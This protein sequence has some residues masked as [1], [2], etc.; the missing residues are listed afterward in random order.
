[1]TEHDDLMDVVRRARPDDLASARTPA[2]QALLEE[3]LS[4]PVTRTPDT[5]TPETRTPE[6]RTPEVGNEPG[7]R[8]R[9]SRHRRL[10]LALSGAAAAALAAVILLSGSGESS[11]AGAVETAL[12]RSSAMLDQSGRAEVTWRTEW[13]DDMAQSGVDQWEFSGDDSSVTIQ[14]VPYQAESGLPLPC[15]QEGLPTCPPPPT[16]DPINRWVDG[17]LYL[18]LAGPDGNFRWYHDYGASGDELVG[19]TT[20]PATLLD[21]LHPGGGFEEVGK[22]D[23]DGVETTRLRATDP[24]Q[25]PV[26]D[27]RG[28]VDYLDAVTSLEVWVDDDGIVRR[29]DITIEGS[30]PQSTQEETHTT[31]IRFFDLGD[32]ITIEAPTD[33]EEISP[34]G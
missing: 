14:S 32:P 15:G 24:R 19:F 20:D 22:E 2:A 21:E 8:A 18:Y 28:L 10:Q 6:T 11:R 26:P 5:R 9:R 12:A 34:E 29:L 16:E 30:P 4:M 7:V 25:T 17:E 33:S 31:S 1:M 27:I 13:D 23:V 3:I